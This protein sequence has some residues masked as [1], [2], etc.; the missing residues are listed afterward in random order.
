MIFLIILANAAGLLVL[1]ASALINEF[2]PSLPDENKLA[3]VFLDLP[4]ELDGKSK[5]DVLPASLAP[6]M[7]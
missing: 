6:V 3:N 7:P 2:I 4:I 1:F 5:F